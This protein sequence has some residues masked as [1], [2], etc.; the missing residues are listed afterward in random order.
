MTK[1]KK[2][3]EICHKEWYVV[4]GNKDKNQC[5]FCL[6]T[7]QVKRKKKLKEKNAMY[8]SI[9]CVDTL[10]NKSKIKTF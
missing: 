5:Q 8:N 1:Q 3:I 9:F 4:K 2:N 7:M 10:E 6:E